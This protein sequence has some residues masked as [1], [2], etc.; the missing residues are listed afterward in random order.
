[1]KTKLHISS[2]HYNT[3]HIIIIFICRYLSISTP[4]KNDTVNFVRCLHKDGNWKC[5]DHNI[6]GVLVSLNPWRHGA[7]ASCCWC[8]LGPVTELRKPVLL[9]CPPPHTRH[10]RHRLTCPWRQNTVMRVVRWCGGAVVRWCRGSKFINRT[11]AGCVLWCCARHG[12][13]SN[14]GSGTR[15]VLCSCSTLA[16]A[17]QW[18]LWTVQGWDQME[19][20]TLRRPDSWQCPVSPG[21][22]LL[23]WRHVQCCP[24]LA[25]ALEQA[26]TISPQNWLARC[27]LE[28]GCWH[29]YLW[30]WSSTE[31]LS[32]TPPLHRPCSALSTHS[33]E[34]PHWS[35]WLGSSAAELA[36]LA[37]WMAR[38]TQHRYAGLGWAGLGWPRRYINISYNYRES[39]RWLAAAGLSRRPTGLVTFTLVLAR[40]PLA[41]TGHHWHMSPHSPGLLH[42]SPHCF[43]QSETR[44][45]SS[46]GRQ[47]S[48]V[49]AMYGL[50]VLLFMLAVTTW[51]WNMIMFCEFD[52][53]MKPDNIQSSVCFFVC[54]SKVIWNPL[55]LL[56]VR[57]ELSRLW[58]RVLSSYFH[59]AVA[60]APA[61]PSRQG[62]GE[63]GG[64]FD[65]LT[66][67][68]ATNLTAIADPT[69]AINGHRP[70]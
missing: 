38:D 2:A 66:Q 62:D 10:H 33:A 31:H 43:P 25:G 26:H 67:L 9:L 46:S 3:T 16:R 22:E 4:G 70:D 18:T 60:L 34:Y 27:A 28:R 36:A 41:T 12:I 24:V 6:L 40:P 54:F 59:P 13:D 29:W 11:T 69:F 56:Q 53:L 64:K 45:G 57:L 1:M 44:T 35:R 68:R 32:V 14:I 49:I 23:W 8:R 65:G 51:Q 21:V 58:C 63:S 61:P 48:G 39:G 52:C 7:A 20:S 15:P 55:I 42:L 19:W 47:E 5:L 50:A 37:Q 17:H 30:R